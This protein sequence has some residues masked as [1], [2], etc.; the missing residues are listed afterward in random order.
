MSLDLNNSYK[1]AQDKIKSLK[2]FREIS[3]AA[4]N[5]ENSN[6]KI[7]FDQF[8]KNLVSPLEKLKETQKRFQRQGQSQLQNLI[9]L[10]KEN[11][12]S[13]SGF[14]GDIKKKF[15]EAYTR[16]EP[17]MK[18]LWQD[19]MFT[20]V[21]C[22]Q[23]QTYTTN[24]ALYI[25]VKS[26]DLFEKL[27]VDPSSQ[28][29]KLF[30][31]KLTPVY[32]Q[33]PFSMN[34]TLY[35]LT[36]SPN[37]T[38][39]AY[40]GNP[41]IGT[42][43]Q[44]LFDIAYVQQDGLGRTGDF[45]KVQLKNRTT[46]NNVGEFLSDYMSTINIFDS[47][48]IMA[49]LVNI[50]TSAVDMKATIGTGQLSTKKEFQLVVQRVLGLC[51]D[52]RQ[53]IDVSG[54]AKV[55]ELDGID[56]SFFT[57][58]DVDRAVI[59]NSI[60]NV[61]RRSMEFTECNNVQVPVDFNQL[62]DEMVAATENLNLDDPDVLKDSIE[63]VVD[64]ISS[65]P[66]WKL[67]FPND[68]NVKLSIDEDLLSKL[69][70]ALVAS[71]L[72]PKVLLPIFI[73]LYAV[74]KDFANQVQDLQEFMKKFQKFF[75]SFVSKVGALFIE[76]LFEIIKR[77]LMQLVQSVLGEISRSKILKQ[78]AMIASLVQVALAVADLI[79]DYRKCKS[80]IDN[81][82]NILSLIGRGVNL[83][84][85][86]PLMLLTPLLGGTSP[87]GTTINVIEELQKFGLP[88]GPD[89]DGSPNVALIA[90]KARQTAQ[91]MSEATSGYVQVAIPPD[92]V[93]PS[94]RPGQLI[95]SGKK[96]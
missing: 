76:E 35:D 9:S 46:T 57:M 2:T 6:Q 36:Q 32:G 28:V 19:E 41:Y 63:K 11:A 5:L 93:L 88:T 23:E 45:Y 31:E 92:I 55:A 58:T 62:V 80:V 67:R 20:A 22:S 91:E 50:L 79:S 61:I 1:Q 64:S 69:P 70:L 37:Q 8:D 49:E 51:F 56:E 59:D 54:V 47:N 96:F 90:E 26:I 85:P 10:A 74:G 72:S 38:F 48:N 87:E 66:A 78:Y 83:P 68:F 42:S 71:I 4:K 52:S 44:Q 27:K 13:G 86:Y 24:D 82:L 84:I 75:V 25:P 16:C 30:Y 40:F 21:G 73:V 12:G 33:F 60:A 3:D 7:P 18:Q 17:K 34:K 43:S 77:D 14:I 65:N 81:I 53:E 95:M 29:G 94:G 89:A 15:L 39:Q